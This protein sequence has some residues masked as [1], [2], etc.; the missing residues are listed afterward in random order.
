M[1]SKLRLIPAKYFLLRRPLLPVNSF[2]DINQLAN[3]DKEEFAD[4]LLKRY[5]E[6]PMLMEAIYTASPELYYQLC[7]VFRK[8]EAASSKLILTLYK[9][10]SR[11]STRCT[12]YGL[13]AGCSTGATGIETHISYDKTVHIKHSRLD[14]NYVNE[15]VD[16]LQLIPEVRKKLTYFVNSSL[17]ASGDHYR[18]I[19]YKIQNKKRVYTLAAVRKS[20]HLN[21]LIHAAEKGIMYP[22]LLDLL[23]TFDAEIDLTQGENLSKSLFSHNF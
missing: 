8:E 4:T 9:Y 2:F 12:P 5:E 6:D 22:D 23:F 15:L 19:E 21:L 10:L 7:K 18:Y 13:F 1:D 20:E 17:Y 3:T 11:M 16:Y 14:M